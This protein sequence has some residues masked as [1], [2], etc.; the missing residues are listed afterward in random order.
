[1]RHAPPARRGSHRLKARHVIHT[2]GPI[3]QGGTAGE[4]EL[5]AGCYRSSL[6]LA[7]ERG[8][9]TIAFPAISTG[10][11]GYPL[12]AACEIAVREVAEWLDANES[13]ARVIFC[14]FSGDSAEVMA[15]AIAGLGRPDLTDEVRDR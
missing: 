6:G 12:E 4:P 3:W 13:P 11:F 8:L 7:R 9:E 5:L 2:V 10:V 14:M 1:M 15:G